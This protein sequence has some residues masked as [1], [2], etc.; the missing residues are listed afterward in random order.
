MN[1]EAAC[2]RHCGIG[3]SGGLQGPAVLALDV[4]SCSPHCDCL[5][6]PL[7]LPV[8]VLPTVFLS[9]FVPCDCDKS[10][11]LISAFLFA[12]AALPTDLLRDPSVASLGVVFACIEC[13]RSG[14]DNS[15]WLTAHRLTLPENHRP[16]MHNGLLFDITRPRGTFA[17]GVPAP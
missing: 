16:Y 2:T 3:E 10:V 14:I 9:I 7:A 17:L 13:R 8:S 1:H 6:R 15:W 11:A 12:D 5:S 4:I